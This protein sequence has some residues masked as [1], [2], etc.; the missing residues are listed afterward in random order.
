M[1]VKVFSMPFDPEWGFDSSEVDRFF[2][3]RDALTATEHLMVCEGQPW[4]VVFVT[5]RDE[6]R[7]G[8]RGG[9]K[10]RPDPTAGLDDEQRRLYEGL[11]TWRNHRANDE[12]IVSYMICTNRQLADIVRLRP[13]SLDALQKVKGLGEAR[14][15][16]HGETLLQALAALT[17]PGEA[18]DSASAD[19]GTP[20]AEPKAEKE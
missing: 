11:R 8:V 6:D 18:G 5:Y 13:K 16:R 10:R 4:L 17:R 19:G 7:A 15:K 3:D 1:K 2:E 12:G 9:E 14:A 20:E